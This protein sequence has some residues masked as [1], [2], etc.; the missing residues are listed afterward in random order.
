VCAQD[1]AYHTGSDF[2]YWVPL[3]FDG[4]GNVQQFKEFVGE[5]ELTVGP[6]EETGEREQ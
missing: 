2:D 6:V 1:P 3:D 5:F 4:Q